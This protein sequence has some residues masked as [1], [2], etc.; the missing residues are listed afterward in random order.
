MAT[1]RDINLIM[2]GSARGAI[3]IVLEWQLSPIPPTP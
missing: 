2:L 3:K 1:L